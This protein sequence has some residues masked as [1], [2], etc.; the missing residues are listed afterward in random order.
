M[1]DIYYGSLW[2]ETNPQTT[3]ISTNVEVGVYNMVIHTL[4]FA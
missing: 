3:Q 4:P 1:Q 2:W